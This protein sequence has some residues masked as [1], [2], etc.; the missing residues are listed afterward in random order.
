MTNQ[1]ANPQ[2]EER[3]R[4]LRAYVAKVKEHREWSAR[5]KKPGE[6]ERDGLDA[7]VAGAAVAVA[8]A[9]ATAAGVQLLLQRQ[10]QQ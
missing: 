3:A 10:Q 6:R 1:T 7:A 4:A 5:V 2:A 9:V 8:V